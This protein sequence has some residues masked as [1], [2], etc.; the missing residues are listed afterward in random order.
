MGAVARQVSIAV[1]R[2]TRVE[3]QDKR[4]LKVTTLEE[5]GDPS[6]TGRRRIKSSFLFQ[7]RR[8]VV[9]VHEREEY[10]LRI[11]RNGKLILTK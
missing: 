7:G 2:S 6:P 8:E 1:R 9:L 4:S 10:I 5:T 11:T 3:T